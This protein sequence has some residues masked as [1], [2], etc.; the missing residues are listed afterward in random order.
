VSSGKIKPVRI[1][2]LITSAEILKYELCSSIID[3][4]SKSNLK[5]SDIA[6][7]LQL[8]KSEVSKIFSY[9]L[10]EFSA[11]RLLGITEYLISKGAG[12][13]LE[14]V[15]DETRKKVKVLQAKK[16]A[17]AKSKCLST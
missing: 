13:N 16:P 15:F 7:A 6:Q 5:Q 1:P 14:S 9:Q 8:N 2:R 12:I 11:E 4:K 3:Y 17:L 10:E